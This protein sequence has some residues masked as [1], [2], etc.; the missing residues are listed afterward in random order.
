LDCAEDVVIREGASHLTLD[1]VAKAAEL[2]KGGLMHHFPSKETLLAGLLARVHDYWMTEMEAR[3]AQEPEGAGRF[4]RA[5]LRLFF[6]C[7]KET[8]ERAERVFVA[9]AAA[10][11]FQPELLAPVQSS[12]RRFFQMMEA[13]G[14]DLGASLV[15]LATLDGLFWSK[16]FGLYELTDEQESVLRRRLEEMIAQAPSGRL[17]EADS[18]H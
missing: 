13:E 11:A 3:L 5:A 15:V 12:Y 14:G 4:A 7:S 10:K 2:S 17:L 1:A 9:L 6:D 8:C 16:A 18:L